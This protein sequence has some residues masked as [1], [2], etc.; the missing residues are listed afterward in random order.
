MKSSSLF[1]LSANPLQR[2]ISALSFSRGQISREKNSDGTLEIP[3]SSVEKSPI[4]NNNDKKKKERKKNETSTLLTRSNENKAT[5]CVIPFP[6]SWP[7]FEHIPGAADRQNKFRN[8]RGI[9]AVL[10]VFM[11]ALHTFRWAHIASTLHW[12][13]PRFYIGDVSRVPHRVKKQSGREPGVHHL[14]SIWII[15]WW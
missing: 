12:F 9:R 4:N 10:P 7:T 14:L 6:L 11:N 1:H 8:L 3:P 5:P 2:E 15:G 13:N